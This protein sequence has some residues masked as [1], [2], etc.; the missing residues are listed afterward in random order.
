MSAG[1]RINYREVGEFGEGATVAVPPSPHGAMLQVYVDADTVHR[2]GLIA[3]ETGRPAE[4]LAES[5][6]AE[7]ALDYFRHRN[8]GPIPKAGD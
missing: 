3:N 6:V 8:G 4:E 1:N 7:A 2:L 5:A